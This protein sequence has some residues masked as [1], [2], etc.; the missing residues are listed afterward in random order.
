MRGRRR[1]AHAPLLPVSHAVVTLERLI[2]SHVQAHPGF[3]ADD[4]AKL[5]FQGAMGMDHLLAD[6]TRF[7]AGLRQEWG[8]VDPAE[9]PREKLLE[10]VH[11]THPIARLN[12]RPAKAAGLSLDL[13]GPLLA[14]QPRRGGSRAAF[15][16]IWEAAVGLADHGK[17][18]FSPGELA[19]VARAVE[20]RGHPP[21]HSSRYEELNRPAYRLIHDVTDPAVREVLARTGLS[22]DLP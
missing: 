19:D 12:L 21:G 4:L 7:L 11:P 8:T 6:R 22:P 18:P 20:A 14:D 17:I 13:L 2:W 3:A 15:R 16:E 9:F 1:P 10:P 5:L